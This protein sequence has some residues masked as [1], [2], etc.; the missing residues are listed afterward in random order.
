[1]AFVEVSAPVEF[2]V[3]AALVNLVYGN[4]LTSPKKEG[5]TARLCRE[6]HELVTELTRRFPSEAG[7]FQLTAS[8]L[9]ETG[10]SSEKALEAAQTCLRL[11]ARN[12]RCRR[13]QKALVK[14]LEQPRCAGGDLDS[15]VTFYRG[16]VRP[17][18]SEPEGRTVILDGTSYHLAA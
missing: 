6:T 13:L 17:F 15:A 8:F 11:E 3:R 10:T 16:G 5:R 12:D 14:E 18:R 7:A 1:R 9:H 2:N 4:C